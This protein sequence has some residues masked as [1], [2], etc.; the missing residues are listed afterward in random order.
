[1]SDYSILAV[2]YVN[3]V[4]KY[5]NVTKTTL[6]PLSVSP[7]DEFRYPLEVNGPKSPAR[8]SVCADQCAMRTTVIE[9]GYL[10]FE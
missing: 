4:T 6:R 9:G 1:M 8:G 5:V 3:R 7:A 2:Q 10:I